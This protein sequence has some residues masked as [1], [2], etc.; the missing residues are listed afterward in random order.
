[1]IFQNVIWCF[2]LLNVSFIW[3]RLLTK[4]LLMAF[5]IIT[6]LK[7]IIVSLLEFW[8]IN[9]SNVSF[10]WKRLSA[11]W[12]YLRRLKKSLCQNRFMTL[13]HVFD[14]GIFDHVFNEV[15]F[16]K[17]IGLDFWRSYL[18]G[19]GVGTSKIRTSKGQNVKSFFKDDHNVE[20]SERRKS[21]LSDF[22]ILMKCQLPMA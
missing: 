14:E 11:K 7:V 6:L 22:Q 12:N 20:R 8:E 1:V 16:N 17:K 21:N 4:K 9:S 2:T 10:I 13:N 5:E 19:E 3:E 18:I 15:I